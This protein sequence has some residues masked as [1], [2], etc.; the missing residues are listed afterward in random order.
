M[1]LASLGAYSAS[2]NPLAV[3]DGP[4]CGR[5]ERGGKGIKREGDGRS[6]LLLAHT[7][8]RNAA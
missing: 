8:P 3:F 6:P 2:P 7:H 4:L 1:R 5:D